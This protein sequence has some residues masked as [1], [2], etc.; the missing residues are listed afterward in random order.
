MRRAAACRR[1]GPREEAERAA[2]DERP[3]ERVALLDVLLE[4]RV[5][6]DREREEPRERGGTGHRPTRSPS[7][8]GESPN[9][10]SVALMPPTTPE[11]Y[12]VVSCHVE[13]PLD[14]RV[15]AAFSELQERRPGGLSIA[16]LIRPP[17]AEAGE[18]RRGALAR[19]GPRGGRP[20]AARPSHALHGPHPRAA[21]AA[22]TH[23]GRV[24]R[25]GAWLRAHGLRPT[26]F[27][28]GGWYTDRSVALACAELGYVDCT[29]R[30]KRPPYLPDGAR[31]GASSRHP[32]RVDVDGRSSPPFRRRTQR[33]TSCARSSARPPAARPRLLPRHGS[34]DQ[35][36]ARDRGRGARAA[37][38]PAAGGQPRRRRPVRARS[39]PAALVGGHRAWGGGRPPGVESWRA[40]RGTHESPARPEES[41]RPLPGGGPS[42]GPA[43]IRRSRV[44]LLSRGPLF[45]LLRRAVS[46]AML[47][48]AD[49]AGLALGVYLRP[50]PAL[51]RLRGHRVL[52]APLGHGAGRVAAVPRADHRARLPA[53]GPLRPARASR[54]LGAGSSA[55]SC[56]SP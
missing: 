4:D 55:R 10:V 39:R 41:P 16:A 18:S 24:R 28:G 15:W 27:C 32:A 9:L 25:E 40:E 45:G 56:S 17:D 51:R 1:T 36:P 42:D 8:A 2:R 3:R 43:D 33:A 31:L 5:P 53:G 47:V 52:V 37:R 14:D 21:D 20:R 6:L 46:V 48:A 30:A 11:R 49:V 54:R 50:R 7:H 35:A 26:L 13:R 19:P 23:G 29:P 22:A 12:A 44:Y 38:T 34:R